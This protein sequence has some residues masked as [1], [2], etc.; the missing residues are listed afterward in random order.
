MSASDRSGSPLELNP[1]TMAALHSFMEEKSEAE[2]R[3]QALM[4]EAEKGFDEAQGGE[5][6]ADEA[7][8]PPTMTVDEFRSLFGEDWQLSQFWYSSEFANKFVSYVASQC[9][10]AD[11][12]LAF[13]CCPTSFVAFRHAFPSRPAKL[14]EFDKRFGLVDK[15]N[16]IF[17]DLD[18]PEAI[19][20][21]LA[22]S[23]DLA[24][25]DPPFLNERTNR[26]VAQ[27]LHKILKPGGRMMILTSTSVL[28]H[29][30]TVYTAPIGPLYRSKMPVEHAGGLANDFGLWQSWST[31]ET[32]DEPI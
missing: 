12:R 7:S 14:L 2:Q 22:G 16:Y 24:I 31:A 28:D 6:T 15:R 21:E 19:P 23:I 18:D 17:Y 32:E 29:L 8:A 9:E 4:D 25:C 1:A 30:R 5:D 3:F 13:L 10:S 27:T 11:Q 20:D 26:K